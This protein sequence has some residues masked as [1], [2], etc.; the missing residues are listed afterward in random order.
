[1]VRI[2][3]QDVLIAL[4]GVDFLFGLRTVDFRVL[5]SYL[6]LT[7]WYFRKPLAPISCGCLTM[8]VWIYNFGGLHY[9]SQ[10]QMLVQMLQSNGFHWF[11]L[12]AF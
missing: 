7:F 10:N 8:T 2:S 11:A 9:L 5:I 4:Q 1:M 6:D 3:Y 12:G